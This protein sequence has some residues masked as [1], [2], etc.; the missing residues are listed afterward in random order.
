MSDHHIHQ[1]VVVGAGLTGV[2]TALALS[3]C[4]YGSAS[5]P[6]ITLVSRAKHREGQAQSSTS[7]HRTTTIN[8]AGMAMLEA[9]GVWPLIAK[10][11]TPITHIKVAHGEPRQGR[12]NRRQRS[13][14]NLNWHDNGAP[15]AY[16]VGNQDL[17]DA[18]YNRLATRPVIQIIGQEVTGFNQGGGC[19]HLQLDGRSD[20]TCQ[21]VV[22]CDGANSRIR[23]FAAIRV[24]TEPH[25]QTAIVANLK[26]ERDHNN[27]A[28]QRF[29]PTGPIAL[30]PYGFHRAALVWSL[31]KDEAGRFLALNKSEFQSLILASF[32]QI[33]GELKID[34]PRLSWPLK[35]TLANQMTSSHLILAGDASHAIHPLAGQGYNLALSD[36]A[37]LA[38][39]LMRANK[40][41]L[42][43]SH[44]SI[45]AD[46]VLGRALEVTTMTAMTSGLNQLMS[47]QPAIAK[48]AGAGM[49]LVN[50]SPLKS[51]FKKCAMG[52]Y[53]ARANLLE[54]RLPE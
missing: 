19:A 24:F 49:H 46:Y 44:A 54:G 14:F 5:A 43:A 16:V 22:A 18:L 33:L 6:A 28:F 39:S 3:Y 17:L 35:P 31:P 42:G 40:R 1:V 38:D 32:G 30:M 52:G 9:L 36:A 34:G 48:V 11:A 29:L 25:K 53:L 41:G 21:L 10:T 15:M 8:A 45:Q 26:L 37:V 7:D 27:T 50:I 13:E 47:F 2:M 20:L 23:K 12:F 51:L 4:G